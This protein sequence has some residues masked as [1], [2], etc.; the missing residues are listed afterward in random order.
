MQIKWDRDR[1]RAQANPITPSRSRLLLLHAVGTLILICQAAAKKA[2][3]KL[4]AR[5]PKAV[6]IVLTLD[7][8]LVLSLS[9]LIWINFVVNT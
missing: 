6:E 1:D 9:L 3:E 4:P 5:K 8:E 2:G 7:P